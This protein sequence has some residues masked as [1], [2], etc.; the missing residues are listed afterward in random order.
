[1]RLADYTLAVDGPAGVVLS[2]HASV[3]GEQV[4]ARRCRDDPFTLLAEVRYDCADLAALGF[5]LTC[6][7]KAAGQVGCDDRFA[8]GIQYLKAAGGVTGCYRWSCH[9]FSG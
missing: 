2:P 7:I 3:V 5:S 4:S 6:K 1:M 9:L 8:G